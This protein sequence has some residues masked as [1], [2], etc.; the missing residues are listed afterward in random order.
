MQ[1][2]FHARREVGP[3]VSAADTVAS[4]GGIID[5]TERLSLTPTPSATA[6]AGVDGGEFGVGW[7]LNLSAASTYTGGTFVTTTAH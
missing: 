2:L 6:A 3:L 4:G 1:Q 7:R 5:L